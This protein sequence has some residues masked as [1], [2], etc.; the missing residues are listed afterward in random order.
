MEW[1]VRAYAFVFF[2][3]YRNIGAS[4]AD[5][6]LTGIR[7]HDA[8]YR[9]D[10]GRCRASGAR[11]CR[12]HRRGHHRRERRVLPVAPGIDVALCEKGYLACEQ[13]GR[14]WGWVR[15]MGRDLAEIPLCL[16]S[17]RLW[18]SMNEA[19]EAETGFRRCGILY[20]CD[21]EKDMASQQ[22]WLDAARPFQITSRIVDA[23]ELADILP[24]RPPFRGRADDTERCARRAAKGGAGDRR[25]GTPA[26][27]Q[28]RRELRGARSRH[29]GRQGRGR[30]HR[31]GPHRLRHRDPRRRGLV[32]PLLGNEGIDL[33]QLKML[34]SVFATAPMLGGP[35][36]T[37]G[38][39]PSRSASGST[40]AT[41]C[42]AQRQHLAYHAKF[43]PPLLRFSALARSRDGTSSSSASPDVS[44]RNGACRGV[45]TLD[46]HSPSRTS[47][48]SI[49]RPTRL[50]SKRRRA[51]S[52]PDYLLSRHEGRR[53][54]GRVDRCDAR[55]GAGDL[56]RSRAC[57]A[58]S[59]P[60]GFRA[61]A[62]ASG[63]ARE[64]LRPSSR[65]ALQPVWTR[66]RFASRGSSEAPNSRAARRGRGESRTRPSRWQPDGVGRPRPEP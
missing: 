9:E 42:A 18:A 7:P 51:R 1:A 44:A 29:R 40:A 13:S 14:N 30:H 45:G 38:G 26:W 15:A 17:Q 36:V 39:S 27:R 8:E 54:L 48:C 61:M 22:A 53:R 21:S 10:Q 3:R 57:R 62:S 64:S 11:R 56:D 25:G 28:D 24:A 46:A 6:A 4:F 20:L 16:E 43:L 52:R 59:S 55:C 31:K 66:R 49:L 63:P 50:S 35:E 60:R 58:S 12:R 65:Q 37:V 41:R 47:A 34:G 5:H 33:P 19:C 23:R 2:C 32:A